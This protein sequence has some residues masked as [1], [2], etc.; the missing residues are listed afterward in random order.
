MIRRFSISTLAYN[1]GAAFSFLAGS[2]G[3]QR[4]FFVALA[5]VVSA[6]IV[7]VAAAF[8]EDAG[9]VWPCH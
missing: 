7:D 3:W 9:A 1:T 6:M 2:A 8:P 4:W 5:L